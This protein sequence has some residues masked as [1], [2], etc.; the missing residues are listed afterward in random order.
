MLS[1]IKDR[2]RQRGDRSVVKSSGSIDL[3]FISKYIPENPI[4]LEAG[5]HIGTD[6][7]KMANQWP[8][9]VIHS[10]E[11]VAHV[12]A[13]L[14]IRTLGLT[15]VRRY[16]LALGSKNGEAEIYVSSGLSD[17]S[18]SLLQPSG[19]LNFH[20]EVLFKDVQIVQTST[21]ENWSKLSGVETIDFMWLDMQ[22]G[23]MDALMN[24]GKLLKT[25]KLV[26]SEVSLVN[27][28]SG[29]PLYSEFARWMNK[30][31]FSV[32]R[33]DLPWDDAGNIA[34]LRR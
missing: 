20:P 27:L 7:V 9:G 11:P 8:S 23:E 4:I 26:Y 33:E 13:E 18:S 12:F 21:I 31:G 25:V 3:E 10:F 29:A 5:A 32:I 17:G 15:N 6:T 16:N 19:H 34:F 30:Q 2:L 22:G 28:Y 1:F 14:K 24:A